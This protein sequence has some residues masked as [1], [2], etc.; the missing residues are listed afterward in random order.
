MP[1]FGNI[2]L[3]LPPFYPFQNNNT[4]ETANYLHF[5]TKIAFSQFV[6]LLHGRRVLFQYTVLQTF[7]PFLNKK[8]MLCTKEQSVIIDWFCN[9][10]PA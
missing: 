1:E 9:K 10:L 7:I 3:S 8:E 4:P 5:T 2:K 6:V